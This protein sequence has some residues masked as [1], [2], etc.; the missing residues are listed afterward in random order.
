MSAGTTTMIDDQGRKIK[1]DTPD[2]PAKLSQPQTPSS[3]DP[4]EWY[5]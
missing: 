5:T 2:E 4:R 3:T 1:S